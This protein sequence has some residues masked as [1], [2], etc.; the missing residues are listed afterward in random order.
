MSDVSRI[1]TAN[2]VPKEAMAQMEMAAFG[3]ELEKSATASGELLPSSS[4]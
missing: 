2:E 1:A 4:S 3:F